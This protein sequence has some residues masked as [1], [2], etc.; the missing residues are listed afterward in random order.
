MAGL[1]GEEIL[2]VRHAIATPIP[3]VIVRDDESRPTPLS[4]GRIIGVCPIL[5]KERNVSPIGS[6][7]DRGG[8]PS[9]VEN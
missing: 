5:G 2:N 7:A 4:I 9:L 1:M 3:G 6:G 8:V